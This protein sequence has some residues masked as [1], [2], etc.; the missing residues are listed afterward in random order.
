MKIAQVCPYTAPAKDSMGAERV[1]E[2]ITRGFLELGH[3][4]VMKLNP[5]SKDTPAPLVDEIPKDCDILHFHGW[6]PK[7]SKAEYESYGIPYVVTMHGG[8]MENDL[9]W[10]FSVN[11]N[12]NIICVSKFISDRL[13]CP[14]FVHSCTHPDEVIYSTSKD[15]YFMWMAGTDWGEGKGLFS[16]IMMAKKMGFKLIIAGTGKNE[17]II[18]QIKAVED[19]KIKYVGP[20]NGMA[21]AA[22]L[23]QAKGF[24]LLTSLPDACPATVSEALMSGTPLIT[25]N[26]GAMPELMD[27]KVGFVVENASDFA[28][29]VESIGKIQP[30]DCREYAMENYSHVVAARKYLRYYRNMI[31]FGNVN[32]FAS[33]RGLDDQGEQLK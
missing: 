10:L 19:D 15:D 9:D 18:N 23:C 22:T 20:L 7:T 27:P 14:A 28:K 32:T 30:S 4:V 1:V 12:P 5:D 13:Q 11:E 31:D 2:R 26:A 29:A 16:T 33:S 3:E 8:G 21:K 24:I 6:D 25:S 17:D